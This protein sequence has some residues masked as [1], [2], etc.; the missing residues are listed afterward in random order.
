MNVSVW[1]IITIHIN[2]KTASVDSSENG[3]VELFCD[4]QTPQRTIYTDISYYGCFTLNT[5]Q[6]TNLTLRIGGYIS[7]TADH[8]YVTKVAID[9]FTN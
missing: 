2:T 6:C 1:D 7:G 9:T 3:F 4:S 5:D 8:I